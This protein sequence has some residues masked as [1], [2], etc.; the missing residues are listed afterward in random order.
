YDRL[1][2]ATGSRALLPPIKGLTGDD[3]S[4][5][6]RVAVFRT[7]DDCRRILGLATGARQALVLGGGLLGLEAARG[8][9]ARGLDV[10]VLHAVGHLMERQLD[11]AASAVL[12][13]SLAALGIRVELEASTA[14][15]TTWPDGF[16][17]GFPGG[18]EAVLHDGRRL[19]A[20]LFVVAC[21]VRPETGLADR[22][23]LAV[24]RGILV[25]DR[26]RTTDSR[27]FAIGD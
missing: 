4:L 8:L 26:L 14:A 3:G 9:A 21:G 22:A 24:D 13:R 23:G 5:P 19:S 11:P 12:V 17:D 16:P 6:D 27:V 15:V 25:D 7:L 2:L 20:D 10:T 18:V 1:V